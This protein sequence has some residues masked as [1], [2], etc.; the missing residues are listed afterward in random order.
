[1]DEGDL[2]AAEAAEFR[3]QSR[4]ERKPNDDPNT[5]F[6][7]QERI[8]HDELKGV[9]KRFDRGCLKTGCLL[10]SEDELFIDG[11]LRG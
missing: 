1:M 2:K 10:G 6:R 4:I 3:S 5:W 8:G 7:R 9:A 11:Q